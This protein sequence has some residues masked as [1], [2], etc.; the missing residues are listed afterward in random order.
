M[1]QVSDSICVVR[2]VL[3]DLP[4]GGTSRFQSIILFF[5]GTRSESKDSQG[6]VGQDMIK[7]F[8]RITGSL[9]GL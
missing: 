9:N 3:S 4:I 2:F 6:R 5:L 7:N 1:I 8:T